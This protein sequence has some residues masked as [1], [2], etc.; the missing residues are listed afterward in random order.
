VLVR[1][2]PTRW[3]AVADPGRRELHLSLG[4]ALENLLIAAGCVGYRHTVSYFPEPGD[5]NLVALTTFRPAPAIAV[6]PARDHPGD[7]P[8]PP[9]RASAVLAPRGAAGDM[10]TCAPFP[11]SPAS[12]SS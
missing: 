4:C 10:N 7:A 9:H 1:A 2:D 5:R 11:A 8:D 6:L 12:G 3:Q